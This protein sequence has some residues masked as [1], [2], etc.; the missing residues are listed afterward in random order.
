MLA[1]ASAPSA[2]V[3]LQCVTTQNGKEKSWDITLN[4]AEGTVDY[5]T[6]I[7]GQQRRPA[8]FTSETVHFIGFTLSRVDLT[9]Q[10]RAFDEIESGACQLAEPKTRAF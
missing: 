6:A 2:V 5:Y 1:Q 4:E 10:R 3:Y 8:R 7:S 9:L